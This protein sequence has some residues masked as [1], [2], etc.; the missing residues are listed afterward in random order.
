[1]A[2]CCAG[3][4]DSVI[5][6]DFTGCVDPATLEIYD[7]NNKDPYSRSTYSCTKHVGGLIVDLHTSWVQVYIL[8]TRCE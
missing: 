2:M 7:A 5:K 4:L 6:C 1:M 3:G 8:G